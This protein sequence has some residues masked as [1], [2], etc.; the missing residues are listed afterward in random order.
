MQIESW[1]MKIMVRYLLFFMVALAFKMNANFEPI[2][3]QMPHGRLVLLLGMNEIYDEKSEAQLDHLFN[4]MQNNDLQFNSE[5][6]LV[7]HPFRVKKVF[8]FS[9][10]EHG[11]FKKLF[12][13]RTL[14]FDGTLHDSLMRNEKLRSFVEP[15]LLRHIST[16]KYSG[17]S[18]E[19]ATTVF[20]A[21]G[22][23]T[24]FGPS[25]FHV[26]GMLPLFCNPIKCYLDQCDGKMPDKPFKDKGYYEAELRS[27]HTL[28]ITNN[29]LEA[30][31]F[32][33]NATTIFN[34]TEEPASVSDVSALRRGPRE[35]ASFVM[36]MYTGRQ[37]AIESIDVSSL[38]VDQAA[39]VNFAKKMLRPLVATCAVCNK[40]E[41]LSLCGR[42]Q[43]IHYCSIACQR[44]SWKTHKAWCVK[45]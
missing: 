24:L 12:L 18:I 11:K 16:Y 13:E 22:F 25:R 9:F 1:F 17:K 7:S 6:R 10:F 43:K 27:T 40:T 8:D 19:M 20:A 15:S 35:H 32:F 2:L 26:E 41:E 36:Y 5:G 31:S 23:E 37:L 30:R 4:F 14:F 45:K 21:K 33:E 39:L 44:E 28:F 42:C 38:S 34:V 29:A 3:Y